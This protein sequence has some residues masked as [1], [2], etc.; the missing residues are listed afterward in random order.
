MFCNF[1]FM[2]LYFFS[3]I[4]SLVLKPVCDDTPELNKKIIEYVNSQMGKKVGRGEC[5]DLAAG[6]LNSNG[7]SWDKAFKY[8]REINA[9][10]DCV[11]PGDI[12]QFENV[13]LEYTEGKKMFREKMAQHTAVI[14]EVKSEGDYRMADQNTSIHG[15]KVGLSPMNLSH[16]TKGK[17]HIY[18]PEKK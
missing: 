10:K 3:L 11:Y 4:I 9:K 15:R 8:G 12:I 14:Y 16:I 1:I 13:T 17:Y 7:A 6:A 2:K 5:W 18:R